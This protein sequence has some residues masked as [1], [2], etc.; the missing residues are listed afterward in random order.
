VAYFGNDMSQDEK[1]PQ[2]D[3]Y[4]PIQRF[5]KAL[6][7]WV[8]KCLKKPPCRSKVARLIMLEVEWFHFILYT[9]VTRLA[10]DPDYLIDPTMRSGDMCTRIMIYRFSVEAVEVAQGIVE[11]LHVVMPFV[12]LPD[13]SGST[14]CS[15]APLQLHL[16]PQH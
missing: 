11:A 7:N 5:L 9:T 16:R 3:K 13:G 6:S 8:T 4:W 15:I 14:T 1:D 2:F 12:L 10:S